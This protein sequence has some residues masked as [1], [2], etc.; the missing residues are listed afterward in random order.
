MALNRKIAYID[1]STGQVEVKP[2]EGPVIQPVEPGI[3]SATQVD[4]G[5]LRVPA[6]MLIHIPVKSPG[7]QRQADD[8]HVVVPV[9]EDP[10]V[11]AV[12]RSCHGRLDVLEYL[13]G[14]L[15]PDDGI[16]RQRLLCPAI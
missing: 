4:E 1:L 7:P 9:M 15:I 13:D 3:Q 8:Q 14:F 10:P 12:F 2:G 5:G 16:F 6:D 11:N